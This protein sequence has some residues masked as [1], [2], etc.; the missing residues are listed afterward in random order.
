MT[1]EYVEVIAAEGGVAVLAV[2]VRIAEQP[3]GVLYVFNRSARAFTDQ[4]EATLTR[5]W[6][7]MRRLPSET[8]GCSRRPTGSCWSGRAQRR[9]SGS[10][11]S[12]SRPFARSRRRSP[13]NWTSPPSSS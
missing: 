1:K 2:P 3:E 9:C 6:P 5:G 8:P 4:Q 7:T 12:S 10:A 13:A 11:R